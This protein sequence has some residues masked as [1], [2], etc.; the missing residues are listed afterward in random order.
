M[1]SNAF[2]FW[3]YFNFCYFLGIRCL[4]PVLHKM[5]RCI[6]MLQ[7]VDKRNIWWNR[8]LKYS[9]LLFSNN[10]TRLKF[11]WELNTVS[12]SDLVSLIVCMKLWTVL[13][14]HI[15]RHFQFCYS[16]LW[17]LKHLQHL[18]CK[19]LFLTFKKMFASKCLYTKSVD[20]FMGYN[21]DWY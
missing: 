10:L 11:I 5:A 1:W 4:E 20:G 6:A 9:F 3:I 18:I 17:S 16:L 21:E 13:M 8:K 15:L 7:L 12:F 19:W 14:I 2:K